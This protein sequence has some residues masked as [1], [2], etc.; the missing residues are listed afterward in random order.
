M[1]HAYI[2]AH[3][4]RTRYALRRLTPD[5][6]SAF[7][8]HLVDCDECVDQVESELAMRDGLRRIASESQT[9]SPMATA[10]PRPGQR[11]HRVGMALAAAAV[12]LLAVSGVLAVSLSRSSVALRAALADREASEQ[13]ARQ[14]A[15]SAAALQRQLTDTERRLNDQGAEARSRSL[16]AAAVFILTTVRGVSTPDAPPANQLAIPPDVE[17]VVL[18][19][20]IPS[21]T[22]SAEYRVSLEDRSG[23]VVWS[24]GTFRPT[25]PDSLAIAI[26]SKL[27]A[28]GDY[29]LELFRRDASDRQTR[30]ARYAFR[31]TRR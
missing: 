26:D 1:D 21:G 6:E 11:I 24:G 27:L 2:D 3:D 12:L 23:R 13:R 14:A 10:M 22:A 25:S 31:V 30:V 5:E 15:Q 8:A 19:P 7:E 18:T 17:E 16:T 28:A 4:I 9:R 29:V 20:E